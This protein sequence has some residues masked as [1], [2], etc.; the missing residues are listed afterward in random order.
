MLGNAAGSSV[1]FFYGVLGIFASIAII[2]FVLFVTMIITV[3]AMCTINV[4]EEYEEEM[5][6]DNDAQ[7]FK[8][9]KT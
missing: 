4:Q 3:I 6:S 7:D 2:V 5:I 8:I 9:G 1:G